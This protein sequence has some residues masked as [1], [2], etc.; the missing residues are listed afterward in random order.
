[1]KERAKELKAGAQGGRG[2]RRARDDRRDEG[3]GSHT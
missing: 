3:I 2:K 1:M